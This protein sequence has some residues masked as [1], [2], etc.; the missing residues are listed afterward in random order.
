MRLRYVGMSLTS[1]MALGVEVEPGAEF[2]APDAAAEALLR[3][4]D[5]ER[6]EDPPP[7]PKARRKPVK[8]D[9]TDDPAGL[10]PVLN[11]EAAGAV[12]DHS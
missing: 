2:Q 8:D 3:R 7:A 4:P 9:P 12:P 10:G 6:V 11:E 5:I 1:F